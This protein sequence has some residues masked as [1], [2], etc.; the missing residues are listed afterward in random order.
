MLDSKFTFDTLG[1]DLAL[2]RCR[3]WSVSKHRLLVILQTV[4]AADLK[5]QELVSTPVLVNCLKYAR[6]EARRWGSIPDFSYA[7]INF[8]DVKHLHQ[9][10]SSRHDIELHFAARCKA[11]IKKLKPTHILFSGD[12]S[13]MYPTIENSVQK[14][15]WV[16]DIDGIKVTSTL[17]L[18]RL[19]EKGGKLANMLGFFCRDAANLML[20]KHP[21]SLDGLRN[22]PKYV[23][24]IKLFDKMWTLLESNKYISLDTETKNLSVYKNVLG[25]AQF[26]FETHP[27]IG[28]V[29]PVDHPQT[30]FTEDERKYIKSKIRSLLAR[31]DKVYITFNGM[32]D[33]R[34]LRATLDIPIIKSK[35]WEI[36]SGEH[37]LDENISSL[38]SVGAA[39]GGLLATFCHYG[40]DHY[41][42]AAF[43]KEERGNI[44]SMAPDDPE[45]LEYSSMDVV[46]IMAIK[47]MQIERAAR[48]ELD[49]KN[50]KPLFIRHMLYQMSDTAHQLSHLRQDGSLISQ[51]YLKSLMARNS[52]L[53]QEIQR[54]LGELKNHPDVVKANET[55]LGAS[56]FKAKS[57]FG[58]AK[59]WIMDFGKTE[60][61][62]E[63]FFSQL[64]LEPISKT[65][66]GAPAIDKNY[67]AHYK[68]KSLVVAMYGDYQEAAKLMSTYV[69]G[70]YKRIRK[71]LDAAIDS[72]LRCDYSS[73][74]V[75]TGRLASKNP[76]LQNIPARGKLAKIIKAMFR[77]PR[78]FLLIRF[79]Y[80]AHEVRMWA[81][82]AN[83]K[84]LA[85]VFRKG[86]TLRKAWIKSPTDAN[87]EAIK[88]DGDVH[89]MNVARFF[90][91]IVDKSHPLRDAVKAV[92]FGVIYG[93]GAKTL[94]ND[95]KKTE[96]DSLRKEL[97]TLYA[98]VRAGDKDKLEAAEEIEEKINALI[99]EDRSPYAQDIMDKLFS[100]FYKGA[101]WIKRMSKLAEEKFYVYSPIGRRRFLPAAMTGDRAIIARQVRRGTNAPIQGFASEVGVKASRLVMK[102]YYEEVERES[103]LRKM[104]GWLKKRRDFF[105]IMFNRIVHDALYYSVPYHMTLP[106]IHILQH[107]AT[108][109]VTDAYAKE[110][111]LKFLIEPEIEVEVGI[112]D[113]L[114]RKWDWSLPHLVSII[115]AAVEDLHQAG[116]LDVP[117][118]VV[119]KS[120]F[121]PWVNPKTRAY[122][123][124]KYP[125]LGVKD[126]DHEIEQAIAAYR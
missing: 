94:G 34:V 6:T 119:L 84:V 51:T 16:H 92:V 27:H 88:K 60:H 3:D 50:Y 1:Y 113:D 30:P 47:K 111:D 82:A 125:L 80:S 68:D 124:E 75:D 37:L 18:A 70:W 107:E 5:A 79:D 99:E 109:G 81:V 31:E 66:S 100:E 95:T 39:R 103:P 121:E 65:K 49:G 89:L 9:R 46:S 108:Y 67:V 11:I 120:I 23:G 35:V 44:F 38:P 122:L 8:N 112:K 33:L 72:Y 69:K 54:L 41:L 58:A 104:L 118:E 56:G 43:S 7:A 63:L 42:K 64:G 14:M 110:F 114:S 21:Y 85:D 78:G 12:L 20:G 25:L 19:L 59:S 74:D 15:G 91:K 62:Q 48:I 55:L 17:D 102:S 93:K 36:T 98:A 115:E 73:F 90:G 10:G 4:D 13:R 24:T 61:K 2:K 83:D 105:R 86:Q 97:N 29:V 117:K 116:E 77:A 40:N 101:D 28:F 32:F 22:V 26:C 52:K 87:K 71:D 53:D 106:F 96:I 126:L 57:L 123:Q 76:N 45:V